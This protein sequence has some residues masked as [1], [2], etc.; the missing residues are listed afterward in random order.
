MTRTWRMTVKRT[1]NL[2]SDSTSV[3]GI[4]YRISTAPPRPL[5]DLEE[6]KRYF[7][8]VIS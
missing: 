3:E 1:I 6:F 5:T 8:S 4:I 7:V 2:V